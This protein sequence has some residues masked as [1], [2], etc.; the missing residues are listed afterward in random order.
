[1][2]DFSFSFMFGGATHTMCAPLHTAPSLACSFL[3]VLLPPLCALATTHTSSD[4]RVHS[5]QKTGTSESGP[6]SRSSSRPYAR[7]R[8]RSSSSPPPSGSTPI[9]YST[10]WTLKA[11]SSRAACIASTAHRSKAATQRIY[12][13][14]AVTSA[15]PFSSRT[16]LYPSAS[17][18][19]MR[20][21]CRHGRPMTPT[22]SSW[23]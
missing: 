11:T 22:R 20:Y 1:M 19:R 5:A 17:N 2:D 18:L 13:R 4:T 23:A 15:R 8:G 21:S 7:A 9:G 3:R 10:Y 12:A 14:W 16:R 6:F